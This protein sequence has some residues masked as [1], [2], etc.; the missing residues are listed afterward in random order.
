MGSQA[1][2]D[3]QFFLDLE[4]CFPSHQSVDSLTQKI[5][6]LSVCFM[7]GSVLG[8]KNIIMNEMNPVSGLEELCV[9]IAKSTK[10]CTAASLR[11]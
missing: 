5:K 3:S 8:I 11:V 2:K 9:G 6:I 7:V 1:E 4:Q 10:R